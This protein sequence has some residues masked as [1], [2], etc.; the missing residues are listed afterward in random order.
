MILPRV[1][2]A[3]R[4]QR[5]RR[6]TGPYGR[7]GIPTGGCRIDRR[8]RREGNRVRFRRLVDQASGGGSPVE[9]GEGSNSRLAHVVGVEHRGVPVGDEFEAVGHAVVAG[10]VHRLLGAP[11]GHRALRGDLLRQR[12]CGAATAV[13]PAFAADSDKCDDSGKPICSSTTGL[14]DGST[15]N[16]ELWAM[17][18]ITDIDG[19]IYSEIKIGNQVWMAENLSHRANEG[20]SVYYHG[21]TDPDTV[22]SNEYWGRLYT[23]ET[24]LTVCPEGWHLPND[25]EWQLLERELGMDSTQAD[26][27]GWRGT[28]EGTGATSC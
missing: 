24:A 6:P 25:E 19:N 22:R 8:L 5:R 14:I 15:G 21:I 28:D 18:I 26:S 16:R 27:T 7:H 4:G 23:F 13:S 10:V 11:D 3:C 17:W 9:L 20:S 2:W 12:A 1:W